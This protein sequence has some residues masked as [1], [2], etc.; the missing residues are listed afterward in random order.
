MLKRKRAKPRKGTV[1]RL[2]PRSDGA[3]DGTAAAE[4]LRLVGSKLV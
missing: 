3:Q 1:I 4:V 2:V